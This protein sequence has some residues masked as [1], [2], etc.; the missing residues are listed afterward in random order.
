MQIQHLP[1]FQQARPPFPLRAVEPQKSWCGAGLPHWGGM[2]LFVQ[3]GASIIIKPKICSPR[4]FAYAP[5]TK[6]WVVGAL[7]K[8]CFEAGAGIVQVMDYPFDGRFEET[9]AVNGIEEQ[10][11]INGGQ[12]VVMAK[13]KFITTPIANG[14]S[15]KSADVYDD[16]LNADVVINVPVAKIH[17]LARLTLG[18]KNMMGFIRE[19]PSLHWNLGQNLADLNACVRPTLTVIDA[20]RILT[21]NGPTGGN[22]DDVKVLDTVIASVD[23]IAA[24]SYGAS[25]FGFRPEDLDYI[26]AGIAAGLGQS[27]LTQIKIEEIAIGA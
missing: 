17:G 4:P 14:I 23:P 2:G 18:M 9:Y 8:M 22:L 27:D 16:L 19:R 3:K 25:L 5:T 1:R 6:A 12:M 10:V 11:Q 20:V 24:D 15:L 7:V 13:F 21:A 26:M